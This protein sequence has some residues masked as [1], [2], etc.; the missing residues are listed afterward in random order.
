MELPTY[1]V[2]WAFK[3]C[4]LINSDS[5]IIGVCPVLF[6]ILFVTSIQEGIPQ[7]ETETSTYLVSRFLTPSQ[8]RSFREIS[9][10]H[11]QVY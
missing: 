10:R 7:K 11:W 4:S 3:V 5:Q 1:G 2:V 8:E 6:L 9:E